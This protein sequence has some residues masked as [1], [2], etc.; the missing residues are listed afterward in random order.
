MPVENRLNVAKMMLEYRKVR[1]SIP[2]RVGA[3]GVRFFKQSFKWQ[4]F[5]QSLALTRWQNRKGGKRNKGRALL[6]DTGRL[7][8]SIRVTGSGADYVRVGTD[9]PYARIHNEGG[10]IT[11]TASV[12][13]HKRKGRPV[14]GHTRNVNLNIPK[15]QFMGN[16]KFFNDHM[17]GEIQRE[18]L[19]IFKR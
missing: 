15:R 19:R 4:G 7:R 17:I 1:E 14:K 8:R 13:P 3:E 2:R 6:I 12:R 10:R 11:G 9:V 18:L 16:S 5:K